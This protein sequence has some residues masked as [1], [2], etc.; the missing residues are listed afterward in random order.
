MSRKIATVDRP[1]SP[2]KSQ[3][4][5]VAAQT[6]AS[7]HEYQETVDFLKRQLQCADTKWRCF[8]K[9]LVVIEY[10]LHFGNEKCV[11]WAMENLDSIKVLELFNHAEEKAKFKG[12]R[13]HSP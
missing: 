11:E 7:A 4:S 10:L 6:N 12:K 5:R 13:C 2:K 3:M 8:F 9:I 1:Y